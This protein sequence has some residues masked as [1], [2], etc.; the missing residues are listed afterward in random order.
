M[1]ASTPRD[2]RA[3]PVRTRV[4]ATTGS[5]ALG[6]PDTWRSSNS[7]KMPHRGLLPAL[8]KQ[9]S[10]RQHARRLGGERQGVE[11]G[12]AAVEGAEHPEQGR[13]RDHGDGCEERRAVHR[14]ADQEG[15]G[16]S[17]VA[18]Q[19]RAHPGPAHLV[20]ACRDAAAPWNGVNGQAVVQPR[21]Q[22]SGQRHADSATRSRTVRSGGI[23]RP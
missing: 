22:E 18:A 10:L 4:A 19:H 9:L 6:L 5:G 14:V 11:G 23:S 1:V 7:V 16:D 12:H 15:V 3:S 13:K 17:V 21:E 8:P 2:S 20:H